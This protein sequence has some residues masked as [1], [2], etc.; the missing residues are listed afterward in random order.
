MSTIKVITSAEPGGITLRIA[1]LFGNTGQI[2]TCKKR[3]KSQV[4]VPNQRDLWSD[5]LPMHTY[6]SCA[7]IT[8]WKIFERMKVWWERWH[9]TG[10]MRGQ[11]RLEVVPSSFRPR[12]KLWAH[13]SMIRGQFGLRQCDHA[14][15][16]GPGPQLVIPGL[17]SIERTSNSFCRANVQMHNFTNHNKPYMACIIS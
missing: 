9:G 13:E 2:I 11:F 17:H 6:A 15:N 14:G 10:L 7:Q 16:L 8:V 12:K 3:G 1:L 4:E 5:H